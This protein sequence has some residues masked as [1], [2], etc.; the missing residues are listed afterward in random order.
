MLKGDNGCRI[1][2]LIIRRIRDGTARYFS[3]GFLTCLN[4]DDLIT[5]MK[6][7]AFKAKNSRHMRP[8]VN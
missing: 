6:S 1:D 3:E 4:D 2:P 5:D 7:N 8:D